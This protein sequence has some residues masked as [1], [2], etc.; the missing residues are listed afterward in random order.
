MTQKDRASWIVENVCVETAKLAAVGAAREGITVTE[1]LERAVRIQAM[2]LNIEVNE[3]KIK[4]TKREEKILAVLQKA[5]D[6]KNK[7]DLASEIGIGVGA[8][9]RR[10][11]KLTPEGRSSDKAWVRDRR[12]KLD[13]ATVRLIRN[14]L[15]LGE[16]KVAIASDFGVS[17]ATVHQIDKRKIWTKVS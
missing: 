12:A 13:P 17:S 8:L 16:S 1:W 2:L 9:Y 6:K 7:K 11:R 15:A 4:K 5:Q 14:R 10:I 3:T